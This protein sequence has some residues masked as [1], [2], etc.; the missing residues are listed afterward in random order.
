MPHWTLIFFAEKS[1]YVQKAKKS[2]NV[3]GGG[4]LGFNYI[5]FDF[6]FPNSMI[7]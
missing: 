4:S 2:C 6:A 3:G 1:I 7:I 5:S